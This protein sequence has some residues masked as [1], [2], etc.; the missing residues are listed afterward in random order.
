MKADGARVEPRTAEDLVQTELLVDV[1]AIEA[2]KRFR[3]G[4][5]FTIADRSHIYWRNP[6]SSGLA[7]EVE[8]AL[9]EGFE[10][11]ELLWP[12]PVR[13]VIPEIDDVSHGYTKRVML[14]SEATAPRDLS[15]A[16]SVTLAAEVVY[17][18]CMEDGQCL[19]GFG[20][21]EIEIPVGAANP[22]IETGIFDQYEERLPRPMSA[23]RRL[24]AVK[25]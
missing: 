14:F 9:P 19:P 16:E 13:F 21:L 20:S 5:E 2:G 25:S 8:W 12:A 22:A 10:A 15:G 18:V 24:I 4:V 17:L 1:R 7:T 3:I 6:G 23:G 11:G